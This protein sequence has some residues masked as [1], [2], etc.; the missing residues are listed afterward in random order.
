MLGCG[1][2][3]RRGFLCEDDVVV[4]KVFRSLLRALL[5]VVETQ[6]VRV[7][8]SREADGRALFDNI[9][10]LKFENKLEI[11]YDGYFLR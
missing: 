5:M 10:P 4:A 8:W 6:C 1:T 7:D 2:R 3:R 9:S 11:A